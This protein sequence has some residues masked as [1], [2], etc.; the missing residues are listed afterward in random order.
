MLGNCATGKLRMVRVP[1]ST[2]TM[3]ITMATMGRLIKN[4]D[5]GLPSR[6][7]HGKRLGVHLHARTHLLH[8]LGDHPFPWL[9]S[10]RNNPLIA[11]TVADFDRADAH[12][13]LVVHRRDLVAA[14][15]F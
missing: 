14:L 3:E 5:M 11:K 7:F 2:S 12:F 4:F 8:A 15:Q 10:V 9:K 6:G 13:V 1:T